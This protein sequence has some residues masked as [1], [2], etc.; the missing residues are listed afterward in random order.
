MDKQTLIEKLGLLEGTTAEDALLAL[1]DGEFL[2]SLGVTDPD[3]A[4]AFQELVE[5]LYEEL[6]L[7]VAQLKE[8]KNKKGTQNGQANS[9]NLAGG[10][11]G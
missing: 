2:A 7:L 8:S 10:G 11:A 5:E 6:S 9:R 3:Q 4:V 1:E